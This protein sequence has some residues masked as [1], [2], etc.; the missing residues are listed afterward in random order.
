MPNING[1]PSG[2]NKCIGSYSNET[3]GKLY[4][5]IW[6]SN[7]DHIINEYDNLT[8][9]ITIILKGSFLGFEE[10]YYINGCSMIGNNLLYWTD[11]FNPPRGIDVYKAIEGDYYIDS[12]SISLIKK[13]PQ[14]L[15]TAYY[16]DDDSSNTSSNKLK[17]QLFQFR[18]LYVYDDGSRSAWSSCSEVPTPGLESISNS[19]PYKNN[20][21]VL[22]FNAGDKYVKTVEIACQVKGVSTT[23]NTTDW[24]SILSVDRDVILNST[25]ETYYYNPLNNSATYRFFN[26]GLYQSIDVLETD[27]SYDFVPLTS[28][29][30]DI[31]NGNVLVL[32]NNLEGYDNIN[33]DTS[34]YVDYID[35]DLNTTQPGVNE[36]ITYFLNGNVVQMMAGSV[37]VYQL[38]K[39][40]TVFPSAN[41]TVDYTD[42]AFYFMTDIN[43]PSEN[44]IPGG[45]WNFDLY[46]SLNNLNPYGNTTFKLNVFKYSGSGPYTLIKESAPQT[47]STTSINLYNIEI[48]VPETQLEVSDRIVISI[49]TFPLEYYQVVTLYTEG[50]YQSKI[51][52]SFPIQ[53]YSTVSNK[54]IKQIQSIS[55]D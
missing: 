23:V 54:V 55:L 4:S 14:S 7:G 45:I 25:N 49:Q 28:K 19:D 39:D 34:V 33:I 35:P 5:F 13:A 1:L 42:V 50:S 12:D 36:K 43:S 3:T 11:G 27:L 22:T 32:G 40:S 18:Y 30:L 9:K 8:N 46:L 24:F 37:P 51:Q 17:G 6:N 15:I 41:I 48:D 10:N 53:D 52:T 21:I 2:D 26:D 47:I 20:N 38:T 16:S 44:V 29:T 31:I